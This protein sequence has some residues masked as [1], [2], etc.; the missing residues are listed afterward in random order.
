MTDKPQPQPIQGK[1]WYGSRKLWYALGTAILCL[2][3]AF[4]GKAAGLSEGLITTLVVTVAG[5]GAALMGTHAYT[6][7][8]ATLQSMGTKEA[9][10]QRTAVAEVIESFLP[11]VLKTLGLV[12][13]GGKAES[14]SRATSEEEVRLRVLGGL[15]KSLEGLVGSDAV[16]TLDTALAL[17]NG[18]PRGLVS[19]F[20]EAAPEE[21][22]EHLR[23]L[24]GRET[25]LS[26]PK[27]L[28]LLRAIRERLKAGGGDHE[29]L[30]DPE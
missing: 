16:E 7:T 19:A 1:P 2:V 15:V 27:G 28:E 29:P 11:S 23:E 18:V 5:I 24:L 20:F 9:G 30:S 25:K 22:V 3:A 4:G 21:T 8:G 6:D 13:E 17:F 10:M 14:I 26:S 12:T